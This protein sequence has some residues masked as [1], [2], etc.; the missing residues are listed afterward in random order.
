MNNVLEFLTDEVKQD[1]KEAQQEG[2]FKWIDDVGFFT[3]FEYRK[4]GKLYI[5]INNL[6]IQP[7]NRKKIPLFWIRKFLKDKYSD[8]QFGY[9]HNEKKNRFFYKKQGEGICG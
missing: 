2:H 3:W 4:N 1:I 7:E 6:W 8:I 9:W 5:Y